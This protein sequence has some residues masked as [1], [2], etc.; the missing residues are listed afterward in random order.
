[1]GHPSSQAV[2]LWDPSSDLHPHGLGVALS[3]GKCPSYCLLVSLSITSASCIR[4]A[5]IHCPCFI[6]SIHL[7]GVVPGGSDGKELS[8]IQESQGWEDPW[9]RKWQPTPEFLPGKSHEQSSLTGYSRW[10]HRIGHDLAT[11]PQP[12]TYMPV[13][14]QSLLHRLLQDIECVSLYYTV[15]CYYLFYL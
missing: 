10:G 1:M 3:S 14:F 5:A 4:A 12:T 2:A 8:V 9:K 6:W 11:K 13:L 7:F 15:A